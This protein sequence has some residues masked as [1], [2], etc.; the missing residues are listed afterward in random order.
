M[1]QWM[2][3]NSIGYERQK[4][5]IIAEATVSSFNDGRYDALN[6]RYYRGLAT[7]L[8][9]TRYQLISDFYAARDAHIASNAISLIRAHPGGRVA[10]VVGADHRSAVLDAITRTPGTHVD[11]VEV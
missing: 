5:A 9:G 10:I 11:V 7:H 1:H 2:I 6:R 8:L 4:S 3:R